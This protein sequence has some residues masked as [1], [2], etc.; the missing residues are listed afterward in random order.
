MRAAAV[1]MPLFEEAGEV[2]VILTKRPDTM[3]S[4]RG[5]IAFP[6]GLRRPDVDT[7]LLDAAL[8]EAEE[9]IGLAREAVEVV[10]ELDTLPTVTT[11][12]LIAPFVGLLADRPT[13]VPCS[14]EVERIFDVPLSELLA[15]GVHREEHWGVGSLIRDVHFFE[16]EDETVWGATARILACFLEL[17][18]AAG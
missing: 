18:I 6:G 8:R 7:T 4:H 1:L 9:E 11:R 10:A 14:R 15:D 16:L 2:R 5:D 13:L 3:P 17:L 12:F